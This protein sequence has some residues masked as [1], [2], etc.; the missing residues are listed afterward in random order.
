MLFRKVLLDLEVSDSRRNDMVNI[1]RHESTLLTP[2]D[3]PIYLYRSRVM[4]RIYEKN[5][6][7]EQT[8]WVLDM[9]T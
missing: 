5:N 4:F 6:N 1:V 9:Y 7:K 2:L 3:V 8:S